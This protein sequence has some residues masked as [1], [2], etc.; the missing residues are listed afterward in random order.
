MKKFTLSRNRLFVL[1]IAIILF[2]CSS[3]NND[4]IEQNN[5]S[6]KIEFDGLTYQ[7]SNGLIE[8]TGSNN[9]YSIALYPKGITI[10]DSN[11]NNVFNGGN[12]FLEV[13]DILTKND[14]ISGKYKAGEDVSVY[15]I[16]NAQFVNDEI[17]PGESVYEVNKNGILIINKS[18]N[19]YE[20]IYEAFDPRDIPFSVYYKGP[21]TEI[22]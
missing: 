4:I 20:F 22:N 21:L 13:S 8:K 1:F 2:S 11:N 16:N 6:N 7:I 10:K 9:E 14:S 15:F 12:W 18:E 3:N 5:D 19:E 17:Q